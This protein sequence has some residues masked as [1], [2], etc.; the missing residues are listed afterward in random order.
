MLATKNEKLFLSFMWYLQLY[1]IFFCCICWPFYCCK[2]IGYLTS[3]LCWW[4]L[5]IR[6]CSWHSCCSNWSC[7][8]FCCI[9]KHKEWLLKMWYFQEKREIQSYNKRIF[10]Y[11]DSTSGNTVC[12]RNWSGNLKAPKCT[13]LLRQKIRGLCNSGV[14]IDFGRSGWHKAIRRWYM[15]ATIHIVIVLH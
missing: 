5:L 4:I 2:N 7:G 14:I 11:W 12:W 8:Q 3:K 13:V 9:H 6:G 15:L 10:A 1:M